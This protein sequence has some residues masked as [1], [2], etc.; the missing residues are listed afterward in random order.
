[1]FEPVAG[2][3]GSEDNIYTVAKLIDD[4][5]RIARDGVEAG[6]GAQAFA[7]DARK[8]WLDVPGVHG[9]D[10]PIADRA[11]DRIRVDGGVVLFGGNLDPAMRPIHSWEAVHHV[12][13]LVA[14]DPNEHRKAF[15]RVPLRV[16]G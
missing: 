9:R 10:F 4:E 3:G 15:R 8:M 7:G 11:R 2:A 14:R 6:R 12:A 13:R 16:L 1:M 5:F